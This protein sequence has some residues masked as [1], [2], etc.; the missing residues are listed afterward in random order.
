MRIEYGV[1]DG[2]KTIQTTRRR[3]LILL[4]AFLL[5]AALVLVATNTFAPAPAHAAEVCPDE[6]AQGREKVDGGGGAV[7]DLDWVVC[8]KAGTNLVN[9]TADGTSTLQVLLD[10][11][12]EITKAVSHHTVIFIPNS[13][14][15]TPTITFPRA[16]NGAS[17]M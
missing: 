15:E 7:Y 17:V 1:G 14:P 3:W 11:Q 16:A 6:G 4:L 9:V 2:D 10:S 12:H 13:P 8:V 5:G